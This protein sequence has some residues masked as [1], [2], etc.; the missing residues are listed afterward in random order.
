[1]KGQISLAVKGRGLLHEPFSRSDLLRVLDREQGTGKLLLGL[2]LFHQTGH[3]VSVCSVD[4]VRGCL[5]E[6]LNG[7]GSLCFTSVLIFALSP[8]VEEEL[9]VSERL[10]LLVDDERY[11]Y[12]NI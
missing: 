3:Y 1:M 12:M 2:I 5:T 4:P 9:P 8:R 10:H 7:D 6:L 11:I